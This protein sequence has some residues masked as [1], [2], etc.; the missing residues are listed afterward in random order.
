MLFVLRPVPDVAK[1]CKPSIVTV[2]YLKIVTVYMQEAECGNKYI[3]YL[4]HVL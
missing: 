3:D 2:F 1:L 4:E